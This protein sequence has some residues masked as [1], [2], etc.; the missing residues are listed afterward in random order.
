MRTVLLA[1]MNAFF[2]SVTQALEPQLRDLPVLIA[3]DPQKRHGI[4]LTASYE[5]KNKGVKTGMAIWEAM[6]YC[7]EAILRPPD[8]SA[9]LDFSN[10][11]IAI[12][13]DF[14]PLVEP[15]SI[16]EAFVE[17]TGTEKVLG[18]P[19]KIGH[20]IKERI[21]NEIGILCSVGIGPSK[22]VAKMAA[23]LQKPDGLTI[24]NEND[25]PQI[26][27][28]LDIG[29][30]FGV[31]HRMEK[32]L[33]NMGI[34]TIGDL[35]KTPVN[36]LCQRFGIVGARLHEFACGRDGSPVEP[37]TPDMVKS[38]GHQ[39]TLPKDYT[40]LKDID[41][42]LLELSEAVCRRARLGN[43]EGRTVSLYVRGDDFS[44]LTRS[45]TFANATNYPWP[46]YRHAQNLFRRHWPA[47]K[48]I[49]LLGVAL[50]K[51]V[52]PKFRQLSL[53]DPE[54]KLYEAIDKVKD[55]FGESCLLRASFLLEAGVFY[56][57]GKQQSIGS[58]LLGL[59]PLP[60]F[61]QGQNQRKGQ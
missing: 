4:I 8:Y 46:V 49:R 54:E 36:L 22:V 19:L 59:K 28:P 55:Q 1:D 9:Y 5:A 18:S 17:L 15:F 30:L 51:L 21:K 41:I 42:V 58:K 50:G 52:Q 11:I 25:I 61:P 38:I 44:G 56:N 35:A 47:N 6:L 31:G 3:G 27:W 12:L 29:K 45:H 48:P 40:S 32:H 34:R 2:A 33:R 43:Y 53:F 39:I 37:Q 20:S 14:S 10:R 7:P 13:K 23:G 60:Y 57:G 26:L 24:I 16:D